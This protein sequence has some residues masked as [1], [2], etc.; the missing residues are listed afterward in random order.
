MWLA[1]DIGGTKT[2]VGAFDPGARRP[3]ERTVREY[4]THEH[5]GLPEMLAQFL[6]DAKI[7]RSEV[8]GFAAGVAGPV[9]AR[10][11][12]LTNVPWGVGADE[13]SR[14]LGG[15][16]ADLLNDLEALGWAVAV[17]EPKELHVLQAGEPVETGTAAIIA[18]GT[19][20][21]EAMLPR[22]GGRLTPTASE[23]GHADFAARTPRELAL[24]SGL[25]DD[26]ERVDCER[27]ISGPGLTTLHGF[28]HAGAPCYGAGNQT[29]AP[30]FPARVA[31]AALG[32]RCPGCVEA[33]DMFVEAY[34]AEAG[35]LALRAVAT[36][37]IFVG[38]GIAPKILP[39]LTA[40][41]FIDAFVDKAPLDGLLRK[42]PVHVILNPAAGLLGAAV[43]AS[44][45]TAA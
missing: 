12:T 4:V 40:G 33:L 8:R 45:H 13:I 18:A 16:P 26:G 30:D 1:A 2:L 21:G 31:N 24:V 5:R 11:A 44:L 43:R 36:S 28:T 22:I 29:D 6:R 39:A 14:A 32:G 41:G 27:V 25:I 19:G 7:D 15:C 10:K 9:I 20:L 34:G 35:N 17:L 38:G 3:A 23:G 42:I 37:G